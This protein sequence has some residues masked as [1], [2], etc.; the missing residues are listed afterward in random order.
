MKKVPNN[1]FLK[2]ATLCLY[3]T[4]SENSRAVAVESTGCKM[5]FKDTFIKYGTFFVFEPFRPNLPSK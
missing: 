2:L 3:H 5:E 4:D 1:K